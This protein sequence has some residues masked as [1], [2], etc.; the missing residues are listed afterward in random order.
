MNL[1]ILG[2][3]EY[4][5]QVEELVRNQFTTIDFLDDNSPIG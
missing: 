2:A 3:G 5:K 1:L 4:G